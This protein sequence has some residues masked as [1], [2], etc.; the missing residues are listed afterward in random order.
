MYQ[1]TS[2]REREASEHS[3]EHFPAFVMDDVSEH[4]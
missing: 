3:P 1:N 2:E 4:K